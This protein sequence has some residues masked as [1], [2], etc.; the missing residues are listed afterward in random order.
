[1]ATDLGSAAGT[2]L[3]DQPVN[4]PVTV[5]PGAELSVGA[6]RL[7][8]LRVA[9]FHP[10]SSGPALEV[11][12]AE[13]SRRMA[14]TGRLT[15]GR[16]QGCD[17][18]V[19][20]AEV[21]R[22]HAVVR[23]DG[24]AI[25]VE[26]QGSSNGTSVNGTPVTG[27]ALLRPGDR[28]ELGHSPARITVS[29]PDPLD[30][31]VT[32]RVRREGARDV[33]TLTLETTEAAAVAE[34]TAA[35]V[36]VL[37]ADPASPWLLYRPSDGIILHPDDDW[38]AVGTRRGTEL[39]LGQGDTTSLP[40]DPTWRWPEASGSRINQ[41]PRTQ[42]PSGPYVVSPPTPPE[43]TSVR[44]RGMLWQ[45]IG[46]LGAIMVGL[47]V[48]VFGRSS[49]YA[50]FGIMAGAIGVLTV[51]T[52]IAG[53]QSRRRHRLAEYREKLVALDAAL[54]G[55]RRRQATTARALDPDA[56]ELASWVER[57]SA[58]LWERRPADPDALRLRIGIGRRPLEVEAQRTR[59][60]DSPFS[61][62][63][64]EVMARYQWLDDVPVCGPGIDRGGLGLAGPPDR[65]QALARRMIV[66]AACLHAPHE[67]RLWV[68]ANSPAWD[69]CRWLPHGGPDAH[70]ALV[71]SDPASATQLLRELRTHLDSGRAG[72]TRALDLVVIDLGRAPASVEAVVRDVTGQGLVVV[73]ANDRRD[74]PNGLE[75]VVDL[76]QEGG[77]TQVG[78][79][80]DGP[81][82][83]FRA[84]GLDGPTSERLAI[85]LGSLV[86]ASSSLGGD[87]LLDIL[88]LGEVHDV[89]IAE[90]WS[91]PKPD[92]LTV[93]IGRDDA[94][95]P[96]TI[97]FRR[98][99]P[100]GMIAGTTG[101]GKSELLQTLLAAL[102][103]THSPAE[104]ALFLIDF[105]GGATFA[106]LADLPH[107][108]GLVT[109]L[110]GDSS[111]ATR[112]FTALDA[113]IDR[114]KRLLDSARVANV[115]D[116]ARLPPGDREPLPNLLV[117]IDEFALLVQRQPEVK[118]RLDT[119][120]TQGRSLGIHL[121]LATQSPSGVITHAIRTNTNLW[122]CLRV[123]SDSESMEL[124]GSKDAS[125]LPDN[126]PGRGFVR[127]GA[128]D[129]LN[130]FQAARIARPLPG[131]AAA[132]VVR[133]VD[134]RRLYLSPVDDDGSG[135][136]SAT[137][138]S[139]VVERIAEAAAA[140]ALPEPRALWLPP[141][142]EILH[143]ADIAAFERPSDRL[144]A[145]VGLLDRPEA[146]T[147]EPYL[148][149]LTASGHALVSGL[150]G[151][152]KSSAL[153]Q[154]GC[155]LA[156]HHDPATVHLYGIES[157]GGSLAPLAPLPHT[158]AVVGIGDTERLGRL[159]DRLTRTI[160]RRRELLADAGAGSFPRW[161][162]AGGAE[163]WIVLLVDDYPTFREA[164]EQIE[165]GRP[166]ELFN[167]ILQNGPGVGIHV[168]VAVSQAGDL[169]LSQTSLIPT[170]LLFRQS[171]AAEYSL[172]E[173]HL[174]PSEV[175]MG[176][177]GR[178]LVAGGATVQVCL[179]DDDAVEAT[180]T[181]WASTPAADRPR[182]IERLP[183]EV[184]R[185]AL[186]RP[187]EPGAVALG[188]GGPELDTVSVGSDRG[189][190]V[191]LVAGP[192]RSGRSTALVS[193]FEGLVEADPAARCT[194]VAPRTSPIRERA[195]GHANVR[196][197]VTDMG[198]VV[199]ALEDLAATVDEHAVVLIDDAETLSATPGA[200]DLLEKLLRSAPETGLRCVATAR[201]NDLPTM[202]DPWIRFLISL[203][204]AVLLQP[205]AD[206]AF[207]FG[208]KVPVIPAATTPGRGVL[209]DRG[210]VTVLQVATPAGA[211]ATGTPET[212]APGPSAAVTGR[213]V[214]A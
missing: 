83:P 109:D 34:V 122:L 70:Q 1:M 16:D 178:A 143:E 40:V 137:E 54:A 28:L 61:A 147:C 77:G 214:G 35:L 139:V 130:G 160:H 90:S 123:V 169:R 113:E 211:D 22:V 23:Y 177:P 57:G 167:S 108:V 3:G 114:R 49:G 150:L 87:G 63:F 193:L 97:G 206:D 213:E 52:S 205:T 41:L 81:V 149:D 162:A 76:D 74:L 208:A 154:V 72:E 119:V 106:P 207:I 12:T 33:V 174:R 24:S 172:L 27:R 104:L 171:E 29:G 157:G 89:D 88:G 26:D 80:R 84:D 132:V 138:L 47:T 196:R 190:R 168:V 175:P 18:V 25:E 71:S 156:G 111:L 135:D 125:R 152:G 44:G 73:V 129:D 121:L 142:P 2:R 94:G 153:V 124:L 194:I 37:G 15:I 127:L 103:V 115:I 95:E 117:V 98:D 42:W 116:Y 39:V 4:R 7:M 189:S 201:V 110:E 195:A 131:E 100:H 30:R 210:Q 209:I 51:T 107:V 58:R 78:G 14:I 183:R 45:V 164:A 145:L 181:R 192:L 43:T 96:V 179:A 188:L 48:A 191:L 10:P 120:A 133:A 199:D 99:G 158:G 165:L 148:F 9:R 151:F 180:V 36:D 126:T 184:G 64:D 197:L 91:R 176:P 65:V 204:A 102:A 46:G 186:S 173:L 92:P 170:R 112:A 203:R 82:G 118:D 128:S 60:T 146:Q 105:K 11:R 161:R 166:L 79:S 17:L 6:T 69:W 68:V 155:D 13:G 187:T 198:G 62:E 59:D 66:E 21:S 75:V 50:L 212:R 200:G 163:P 85:A 38:A 67:L 101:S 19:P 8:V 159:L 56:P 185:A 53:D 144:V 32:V 134:G 55:E 141:L 31:S 93:A 202:Y 182:P 5:A 86:G 136:A 20:A 140:L